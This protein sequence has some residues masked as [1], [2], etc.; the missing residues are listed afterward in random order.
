M[1]HLELLERKSRLWHI[2]RAAGKAVALIADKTNEAYEGD[3]LLRDAVA[4]QLIRIG[5]ALPRALQVHP[6]LAQHIS[7]TSQIVSLGNQLL[8]NYPGIDDERVW[9]IVTTDL[10]VLLR[11]VRALL[12]AS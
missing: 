5:E 2:E 11:E 12:A 6:E 1:N 8:R 10:P 7:D 9:D 3:D 4:M